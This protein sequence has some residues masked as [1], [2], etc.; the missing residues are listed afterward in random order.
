VSNGTPLL[1]ERPASTLVQELLARIPGY[2]PGWLPAAD[3]P[4]WALLQIY[5]RYL[6]ALAER[7]NLAPDKNK[8]A[9]LEMLGINLLPAQ[10]ARAPLVFQAIEQVG[11]SRVPA[12]TQVGAQQPGS[13]ES[14]V[15]ET[16][17]GIA[18]T[19]ARL[20][21]VVTLWPGKDAYGDHSAAAMGG[22]PFRLFEP[23]QPIPHELY[24]AHDIYFALAGQSTVELQ[25]DLAAAGSD[26]L[27]SAWE[28]WDGEVWRGFKSFQAPEEADAYAALDGTR[29]F[30]RSGV[31]RLVSDCAQSEPTIVNGIEAHWIRGRSVEPIPPAPGRVLPLAD[32]IG[33]QTV[34]ARHCCT[35]SVSRTDAGGTQARISG[36]VLDDRGHIVAF[37]AVC[38]RSEDGWTACA[39]REKD[40]SFS[41]DVDPNAAYT[42][43]LTRVLP[44][45]FS[46]ETLYEVDVAVEAG[47]KR[48]DFK[49]A[50]GIDPDQAFADGLKLDLSKSFYPFGQ[51]PQPGSS[52]YFTSA[53][54]FT[55]PGAAVTI[56]AVDAKTPREGSAGVADEILTPALTMEY[57]NGRQWTNMGV[58]SA[59]LASTISVGGPLSLTVPKGMAKTKVN[60][61]EG[62]WMRIR[63]IQGTFGCKR[64]ITWTDSESGQTNT[65]V[66]TETTPPALAAFSLGYHYRSAQEAPQAC[67]T[68][69][70]FQW[71]DHSD[72]ARWRGA[73][74]EPFSM[75]QDRTP[76]LYLGFDRPLPADLIGLYLDLREQA[77]RISGPLL[78]WEYWDGSS[79][80]PLTVRDE[81]R[82]LVLPGTV[83]VLWPGV[84][85][86]P[87][88]EAVQASGTRI[89]LA[90]AHQAAL[91]QPGDLLYIGDPDKG[92]TA[93]LAGVSKTIL[94]LKTPLS[95]AYERT[96]VR[97]AALPRFGE[98]R[99]WMRARL[100]AGGDPVASDVQG[101]Y[102]NAVWASQVETVENEI[103]GSSSEQPNQ[104]FFFRRTPVLAGEVVEVR[105]LSGARAHVEWP[106]LRRELLGRGTDAEDLRTVTDPRTG[107]VTEVWVRWH[108]RPNFF[109]STGGDR[110][111]VIE[112]SSGRLI[113]GDDRNGRIPPA[114]ADNIRSRQYRS[115]GGRAGNVP[116]GAIGQV[117]SGVLA[118][119]AANPQPAEGGADGEPAES[120]RLRGPRTVRHRYQAVTMN[121]YED[122]AREAS[123]AVAVARALP[124]VHPSGRSAHGWVRVIV[125]PQSRDARPQP[126]FGL[127]RA[128]RDF[129]AARA[130]AAMADRITVG[131]PDYMPIG[132]EA[133]LAPLDPSQAGAVLDAAGAAVERFFHPL[134][135]GPD[136]LGWPFGRDLYLSD[137]AAV[138]ETVTG[139]DYAETITL[140]LDGTPVGDR[141]HVPA[142]RIVVAGPIRMMLAGGER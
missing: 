140:L 63:V 7:L 138:L 130:P 135:G 118:E 2:V 4:G 78:K 121:D 33:V 28:Y 104:T 142:D 87:A 85:Q 16:E 112:R 124:N 38:F 20:A 122:L 45:T 5:G 108:R 37:A 71:A 26:L 67:L 31:I 13:D 49:L 136:G 44:G 61:V 66:L 54:V 62:L 109:F 125:V 123:P 68:Y 72:D 133:V 74:F 103:L 96:A 18:L 52:F 83:E 3:T 116:A 32:C 53:E 114:G 102:V 134:T 110:H 58:K 73:A 27:K 128:V 120:A 6:R 22:Q 113:F 82:S 115:G 48:L 70:D 137:L 101:I 95:Q 79:W 141:V 77:G 30:T 98:P 107:E 99:T 97:V 60:D 57:W 75:V 15:F 35:W 1:E 84:P 106:I 80:S 10:P 69:N 117:L 8:M 50:H 111:Y 14:L 43:S 65:I 100:Q 21:E 86:P 23:L 76:T 51:Q 93:S 36:N 42:V 40:G 34:I 88:A 46:T 94:Q 127:R 64:T 90:N 59:E 39:L 9:F 41:V 132:V 12:R 92:E 55:K 11:D 91:F 24:L 17:K 56:C 25:F 19:A 126:S 131:G 119:S 47:E 139:V 129:L 29:G 81:T 105:E 89:E